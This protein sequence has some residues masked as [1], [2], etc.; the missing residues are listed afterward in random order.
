M[1]SPPFD[2]IQEQAS[3][4]AISV[5]IPRSQAISSYFWGTAYCNPHMKASKH[6]GVLSLS[7]RKSQAT[8]L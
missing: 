2:N 8:F 1:T 6:A 5:A 7:F 4:L 3:T